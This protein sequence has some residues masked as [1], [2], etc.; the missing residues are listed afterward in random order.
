MARRA[1]GFKDLNVR[2]DVD[3]PN[4]LVTSFREAAQY[5]NKLIKANFDY[6]MSTLGKIPILLLNTMCMN[7]GF[8]LRCDEIKIFVALLS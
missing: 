8:L 4:K 2:V 1:Q 7:A 3:V 5:F 6:F